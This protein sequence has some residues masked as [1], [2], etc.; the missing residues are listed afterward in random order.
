MVKPM[1]PKGIKPNAESKEPGAETGAKA[2]TDNGMKT[3]IINAVTT[4]LICLVFVGSNYFI[5]KNSLDNMA[6]Q[7]VTNAGGAGDEA[8]SDQSGGDE[9]VQKPGPILDL[10]QFILNLSDPSAKRYL[11][12]NVAIQLS[13]L[14]TDPDPTAVESGGE[15]KGPADPAKEIALQYLPAIRDAVI[16]TLSAKTAEELSSVAGKELAKQQIKEAVDAIL[17]GDREVERVSFGD[18]I[19]Q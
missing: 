8:G 5:T 4:I 15:G 6:K 12:I 2:G 11:K 7:I 14:D 19:I 17:G 9:E 10:G 13:R 18:F 16:S 3:I 1:Q